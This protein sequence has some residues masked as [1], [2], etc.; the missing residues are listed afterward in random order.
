MRFAPT[1]AALALLA[2]PASAADR[3]KTPAQEPAPTGNPSATP[4]R[5]ALVV[6]RR[7]AEGDFQLVL[8]TGPDPDAGSVILTTL[9]PDKATHLV[10]TLGKQG[11]SVRRNG[12]PGRDHPLDSRGNG[13][14]GRSHPSVPYVSWLNRFSHVIPGNIDCRLTI[15]PQALWQVS[16]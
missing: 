2:T 9:E 4:E 5:L 14:L 15:Q 12:R 1:F 8:V 11:V 13:R 16:K 10:V 6:N 3:Q 7:A